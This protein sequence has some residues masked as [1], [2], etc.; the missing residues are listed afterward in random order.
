MFE[1]HKDLIEKACKIGALIQVFMY[2]KNLDKI[3]CKDVMEFL[4]KKEIFR[5]DNR[6]GKPLRD[7]LRDLDDINLLYVIPGLICERKPINR[8]WSFERI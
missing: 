3:K 1:Q 2:E 5:K 6:K 8:F 7:V 4:I